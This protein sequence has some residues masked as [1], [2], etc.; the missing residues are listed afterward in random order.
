MNNTELLKFEQAYAQF[1]RLLQFQR[2][3]AA[4]QDSYCRAIR[5]LIQGGTVIFYWRSEPGR[6]YY[7]KSRNQ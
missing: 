7:R 5:H 4:T 2:Y 3:S 6:E 1:E